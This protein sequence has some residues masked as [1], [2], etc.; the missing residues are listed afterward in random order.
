MTPR[1][2]FTLVLRGIGAWKLIEALDLFVGAFNIHAGLYD[3]HISTPEGQM[4]HGLL[5][6]VVGLVLLKAA[7]A[8]SALV[9]PPM[10][11]ADG[12]KSTDGKPNDDQANV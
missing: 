11:A 3:T 5:F 2:Y 1:M 7:P 4:T 12:G 9:V 6:L 8:I 10:S